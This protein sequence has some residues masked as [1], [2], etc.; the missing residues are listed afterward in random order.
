MLA[1]ASAELTARLLKGGVFTF[2]SPLVAAAKTA[3]SRI[4]TL[5]QDRARY[6]AALRQVTGTNARGCRIKG[7]E[8][9]RNI[10]EARELGAQ[11][12]ILAA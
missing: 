11:E 7:A 8:L 10:G 9:Q 2:G 6:Y 3:A 4:N 5:F 1:T 12:S